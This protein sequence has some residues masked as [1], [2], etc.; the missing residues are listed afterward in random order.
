MKILEEV[1]RVVENTL[2]NKSEVTKIEMEGPEIAIYTNNPKTFFENE[3][4]V[5]SIASE[6]KKRIN[7]R[8]DKSLLIEMEDAK[9]KIMKLIPEDAGVKDVSFEAP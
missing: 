5:A 8:T 9:K 6:L 2:P 3:R 4:Y 1:K 7:I